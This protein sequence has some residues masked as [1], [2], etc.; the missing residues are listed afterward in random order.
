MELNP[1]FR[2]LFIENA[3]DRAKRCPNATQASNS[4]SDSTLCLRLE[5]ERI[6]FHETHVR[7]TATQKN[8]KMPQ[9]I[10]YRPSA[11]AHFG[12]Y[13]RYK[14]IY[15]IQYKKRIK[16]FKKGSPIVQSFLTSRASRENLEGFQTRRG[17]LQNRTWRASRPDV[18]FMTG[19]G[20]LPD[21]TG[22]A[23]RQ[24]VECFMT[25]HGGLHERTWRASR[26][27]VS[28]MTGRGGLQ[29]RTFR[30]GASRHY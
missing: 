8:T 17:W 3:P 18:S 30:I 19:R 27:D 25:R 4:K 24:D 22:M 11:F 14:K 15:T 13:Q 6:I 29:G 2:D 28:F 26:L 23:S 16:Q 10:F 7:L 5:K 12:L 1:T 21:Q 9:Y 20:E